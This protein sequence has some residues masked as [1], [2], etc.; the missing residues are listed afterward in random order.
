M[1]QEELKEAN[2][3]SR[4]INYLKLMYDHKTGV[5][6]FVIK[7]VIESLGDDFYKLVKNKYEEL[8][9]KLEEL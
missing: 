2:K 1:T 6:N 8:K 3:L 9:K 5:E 4:K 7:E